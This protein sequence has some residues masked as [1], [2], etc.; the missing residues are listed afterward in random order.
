M[1]FNAMTKYRHCN[2]PFSNKDKAVIRNLRHFKKY[3]LQKIL[4]KFLKTKC[5]ENN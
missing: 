4:T 5:K 2:M 1:V 3:V